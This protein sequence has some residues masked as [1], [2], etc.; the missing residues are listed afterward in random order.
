MA[1]KGRLSA[2]RSDENELAALKR[3]AEGTGVDVGDNALRKP[4][5]VADRHLLAGATLAGRYRIDSPLGGGELSIVYRAVDVDTGRNV[6]VKV[7]ATEAE[8]AR[9]GIDHDKLVKRFEREAQAVQALRHP[10][11][12]RLHDHGEEN[13]LAFMVLELVDGITLRKLLV[14]NKRV[15]PR[16]ACAI[17]IQLCL[18]LRE[19]H[20]V[21]IVHRDLKPENVMVVG[22]AA[23][24]RVKVLDFGIVKL[25][26]SH[27]DPESLTTR[28]LTLGTVE[29]MS[30]EQAQGFELDA[31]ADIYSVG[32]MLFELV[33]GHVPFVA[34]SPIRVL[35]QHVQSPLPS[36]VQRVPKL[37]RV[38]ELQAIVRRCMAKEPD[39][40]YADIGELQHALEQFIEG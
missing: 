40:R 10:N 15:E 5:T 14:R 6:A 31:R 34:E 25:R 29:Y 21:G 12:V 27:W 7:L 18:S 30:P 24:E 22:D 28:G 2:Y 36:L 11:T 8:T 9:I 4:P 39:D 32:V 17:L 37:P 33:S 38:D 26:E 19:A 23:H 35:V 13:G 16:R 3:M 1:T 20:R